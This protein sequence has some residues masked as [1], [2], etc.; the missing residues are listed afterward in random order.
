MVRQFDVFLNTGQGGTPK[1][2]L[3][4][5]QFGI[6]TLWETRSLCPSLSRT[7]CRRTTLLLIINLYIYSRYT[8]EV[9]LNSS[10]FRMFSPVKHCEYKVGVIG[11]IKLLQGRDPCSPVAISLHGILLLLIII[12][13]CRYYSK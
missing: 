3:F 10:T 1:I 9:I 6:R 12:I 5:V 13:N 11:A 2:H 7:L 8:K 4:S